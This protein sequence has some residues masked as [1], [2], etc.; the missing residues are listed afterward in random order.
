[1][2]IIKPLLIA[3]LPL[4]SVLVSCGFS[5]D[6]E[7]IYQSSDQVRM[8]H[9]MEFLTHRGIPFESSDGLIRYNSNVKAEFKT[10]LREYDSVTTVQFI[11]PDVRSYFHSILFGEG[12]EYIEPDRD[13]GS[14]TLWWPG[15]EERRL[16]ILD[17]V[18][19]YQTKLRLEL[20]SDCE[21]SSSDTFSKPSFI[22]DLLKNKV[23]Q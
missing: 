5:T 10:A 9:L 11:D 8:E 1:M 7:N 21:T 6:D 3:L 15:S 14:W 17:R 20:E 22:Q 18:I 4:F 2:K 13:G 19:E 12:I 16:N 23:D